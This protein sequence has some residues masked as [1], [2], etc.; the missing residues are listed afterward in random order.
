VAWISKKKRLLG[1]SFGELLDIIVQIKC[2][3][4]ALN[5]VC[6]EDHSWQNCF[7]KECCQGQGAGWVEVVDSKNIRK[8]GK[9]ARKTTVEQSEINPDGG[10]TYLMTFPTSIGMRSKSS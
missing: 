3:I 8:Y 5:L 1:C 7:A 4:Q 2:C 10:H 9:R 6:K